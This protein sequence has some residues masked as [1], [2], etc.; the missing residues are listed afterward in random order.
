[1]YNEFQ[2]KKA[3]PCDLYTVSV[4]VAQ[5]FLDLEQLERC[6]RACAITKEVYDYA[7]AL[8]VADVHQRKVPRS[9][10]Q[11][12]TTCLEGIPATGYEDVVWGAL[13]RL[14]YAWTAEHPKIPLRW[15]GKRLPCCWTSRP[16]IWRD[17]VIDT[18]LFGPIACEIPRIARHELNGPPSIYQRTGRA[19]KGRWYI[20][21]P[22]YTHIKNQEEAR[23]A[24]LNREDI[25]SSVPPFQHVFRSPTEEHRARDRHNALFRGLPEGHITFPAPSRAA[26]LPLR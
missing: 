16:A 20:A 4:F 9:A 17:Y 3:T 13:H 22:H 11:L 10:A 15:D 23:L 25:Y 6:Q 1:M 19:Q 21:L 12:Y 26:L 18:P 14:Q 24:V 7:R 8:K 2:H 5:V